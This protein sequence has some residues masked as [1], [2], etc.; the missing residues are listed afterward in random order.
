MTAKRLIIPENFPLNRDKYGDL[1]VESA[2]DVLDVLIRMGLGD[3]EL[4]I[5][6]DG[7]LAYAGFTDKVYVDEVNKKVM[8]KE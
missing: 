7:N 4:L 3:Y 6:Y 5:G 8:V 1:T 2:R